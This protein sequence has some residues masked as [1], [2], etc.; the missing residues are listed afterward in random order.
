MSLVD[1]IKSAI[2]H[3]ATIVKWK[4]EKL[5]SWDNIKTINWW[6]FLWSGNITISWWTTSYT[7][8]ELDFWEK[9]CYSKTFTITDT[10]ISTA[11][12]I[13]ISLAS[14]WNSRPLD[15]LECNQIS[16]VALSD[17]W[18]FDIICSSTNWPIYGKYLFNYTIS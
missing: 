3:I 18:S 7:T 2:E 15:E 5:V 9:R 6:S 14:I 11:S 16:C 4:Q 17:D 13:I 10:N 1:K 12:K 8:I